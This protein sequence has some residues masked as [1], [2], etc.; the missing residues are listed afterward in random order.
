M[1]TLWWSLPQV[2]PCHW[3]K[4]V[5]EWFHEVMT[6]CGSTLIMDLMASNARR[7]PVGATAAVSVG[8]CYKVHQNGK[9]NRSKKIEEPFGTHFHLKL[10]MEWFHDVMTPYGSYL[11]MDECEKCNKVHQNGKEHRSKKIE[12]P[13]GTHFHLVV[14]CVVVVLF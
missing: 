12:E 10:V 8:K 3:Q 1:V 9:R 7:S 13:F 6:P 2:T 4:L 11:I 14:N 5:T